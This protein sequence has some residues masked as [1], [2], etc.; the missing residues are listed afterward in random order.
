MAN[1][2][3]NDEYAAW[4]PGGHNYEQVDG[5]ME[6]VG[7]GAL[8][9]MYNGE[10]EKALTHSTRLEIFDDFVG[11]A[12]DLYKWAI[13]DTSASGTPTKDIVAGAGG[14]LQF[15][16]AST[17]EAE[18][19]CLH[20]GDNLPFEPSK[21]PI[22]T[23]R[24][25]VVTTDITTNEIV[26]FGLGT[27]Q[28]DTLDS[29]TEHVMFRLDASMDLLIETDDGTTNDD[30]NDTTVDLVVDTFYEF[31]IDARDLEN[32]KFFYRSAAGGDWTRLLEGTT[33]DVS[34][35][36]G[37]WQPFIQLQKAS[38]TTTPEINVDWVR[39]SAER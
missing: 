26:G 24:L 35:A 23:C 16:L 4:M 10:E 3:T 33:F 36:S 2:V 19:L 7:S 22:F 31:K 28:N 18:V 37:N 1:S 13:A 20:T 17:S 38:G 34:A 8:V 27:A 14:L 29:M 15:K 25:K 21:N 32:V 39:A 6:D 5:I 12:V 9:A 30:D 11:N